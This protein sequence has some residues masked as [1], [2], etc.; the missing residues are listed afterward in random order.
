MF[1]REFTDFTNDIDASVEDV[2]AFFGQIEKWPSWTSAIR[3]AK[4]V[5]DGPW[6]IGY[7]FSMNA[8]F[9]PFIPLSITI[10][11]YEEHKRIGWGVKFPGL[12]VIHRFEFE[13]LGPSRIR[14]RNT[15]FA[16]GFLAILMTPLGGM[17]DRFDRQWANDL[18]AQ[19][20]KRNAA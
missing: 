11:E 14:V 16:D 4:P 6:R 17:I 2:F 20:R 12:Q 1:H 19:F 7:R 8:A 13:R 10:F 18:E 3:K 5:S 9:A 15:E